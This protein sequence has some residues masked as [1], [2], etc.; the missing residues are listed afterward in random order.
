MA[1]PPMWDDPIKFDKA[2]EDYFNGNE[3]PTWTGLAL[4]LGFESRK[5]LHDY[6]QKDGFSYSIKKALLR[7]EEQYEKGLIGRNPAGSIFALKNFNWKDKQEVEQS[8]GL[9][10]RAFWD[11]SLLP[12]SDT[13]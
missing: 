1:R 2:V 10:I 9:E 3:H 5:S 8:G 13:E 11:K 6:G 12:N 4:H 7:I